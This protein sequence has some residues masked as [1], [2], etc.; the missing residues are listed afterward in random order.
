MVAV[1]RRPSQITSCSSCNVIKAS[2]TA[3]LVRKE[4]SIHSG[5]IEIQNSPIDPILTLAVWL[6]KRCR[7]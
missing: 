6:P 2:S 4:Q 5:S 1:V 3:P 7:G